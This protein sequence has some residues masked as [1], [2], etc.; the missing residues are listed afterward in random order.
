M[1]FRL[2][3]KNSFKYRI[4]NHNITEYISITRKSKIKFMQRE[5]KREDTVEQEQY[6]QRLKRKKRKKVSTPNRSSKQSKVFLIFFIFS[7]ISKNLLQKHREGGTLEKL[8][9]NK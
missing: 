7:G 1:Q 4:G 6:L 3:A 8:V 9:K 2:K 5:Q